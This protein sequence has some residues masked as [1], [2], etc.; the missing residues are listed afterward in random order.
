[1]QAVLAQP[2]LVAGCRLHIRLGRTLAVGLSQTGDM[3]TSGE[4]IP[5]DDIAILQLFKDNLIN[6]TLNGDTCMLVCH[7]HCFLIYFY[8]SFNVRPSVH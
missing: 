2:R 4:E 8:Y 6:N 1:M 7:L 5:L 3:M